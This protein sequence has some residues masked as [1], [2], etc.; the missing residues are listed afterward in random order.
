VIEPTLL[1]PFIAAHGSETGRGLSKIRLIKFLYLAD[2]HSFR[3]RQILATGYRWKFYHY[4]PW[5]GEAQRDI[6]NLVRYHVLDAVPFAREA[7]GGE[8]TLYAAAQPP[9]S[10]PEPF[11]PTV[12]VA[13]RDEIRRWRWAPLNLFLNYIYF[14]TPPMRDARRGDPLRFNAELF[15]PPAAELSRKRYTSR[16]SREAFSRVLAS[17][18]GPAQGAPLPRDAV[19]DETYLAALD[20]LDAQDTVR[21]LRGDAEIDPDEVA[22]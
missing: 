6:D 5:T 2:V 13:L 16:Q 3:L 21:G 17:R 12:E 20:A 15:E 8:I 1:I 14:D 4:G 18:T 10:L 9:P 19:L 11:G 22:D 7:E